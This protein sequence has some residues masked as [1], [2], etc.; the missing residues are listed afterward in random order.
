MN[1]RITALLNLIGEKYTS[2]STEGYKPFDWGIWA[3]NFTFDV[4]TQLGFSHCVQNVE[5]NTDVL[6]YYQSIADG[7]PLN[8]VFTVFPFIITWMEKSGIWPYIMPS[9]NDK[10]GYGQ[11]LG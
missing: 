10:T 3:S 7:L 1:S 4:I 5:N 11:M 8:C 2:S 9:K 6:G